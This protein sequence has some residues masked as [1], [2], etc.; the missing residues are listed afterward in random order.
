LSHEGLF[1]LKKLHISED[2]WVICVIDCFLYLRRVYI[3]SLL[4]WNYLLYGIPSTAPIWCLKEQ[5]HNIFAIEFFYK[6]SSPKPLKITWGSFQ[7]FLKICRDIVNSRCTT[8]IN[9][10]GGNLATSIITPAASFATDIN[11][12]SS[13][14]STGVGVFGTISDC[15]HV[16]MKGKNW[17]I[18]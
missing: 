18:C 3:L 10:T 14:F 16:K 2:F 4:L 7:V 15:L 17:S 13:K 9:D 11:N 5:C 12:A 6:S 1:L 8:S